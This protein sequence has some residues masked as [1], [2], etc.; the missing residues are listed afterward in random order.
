[1]VTRS[2]VPK[3]L[4]CHKATMVSCGGCFGRVALAL[5][6]WRRYPAGCAGPAQ[7]PSGVD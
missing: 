2:G 4:K 5:W 7:D 6:G 3:K 1:M